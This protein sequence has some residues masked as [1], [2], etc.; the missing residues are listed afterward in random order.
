[1]VDVLNVI[2]VVEIKTFFDCFCW[3]VQL[4]ASA[5]PAPIKR[6]S[7]FTFRFPLF[8]LLDGIAVVGFD[9]EEG[10]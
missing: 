2:R 7:D 3:V 8:P 1:M 5:L 9:T 10:V 4:G 6:D